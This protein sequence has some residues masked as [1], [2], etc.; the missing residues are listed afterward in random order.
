MLFF[1]TLKRVTTA[2][3][4]EKLEVSEKDPIEEQ[5]KNLA[6]WTETDFICKNLILN[7]LTNELYDYYSTMTTAKELWD[8]LQKKYDTEEAGLKKYAV[9]DT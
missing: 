2:C 4:S 8:A 7:G 9:S 6:T 3:T 1:L 5:L